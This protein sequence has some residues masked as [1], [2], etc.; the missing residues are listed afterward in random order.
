MANKNSF[1]DS[2]LAIA[3]IVVVLMLI[4]PLPT[5]LLDALMAMNV[6][7]S[8]LVLL[9]VIYTPRVIDFSSFPSVLLYLTIFSLG[10]NVSST[11]L[12]LTQG[13][14]FNGQMVKAFARFVVGKEGIEGI[15]V[16]FVIFIIL[17]V[18]QSI[19]ISKGASRVAEVAARFTLDGM[20]LKMNAVDA[21]FHS[22]V[23]SEEEARKRKLEIQKESDFF[24]NMD[25]STKFVSGNVKAGIFITV[26]NLVVGLI[27]GMVLRGESFGVAIQTYASLTIGDGLLSQI[28]SLL[29]SFATGLIVTRSASDGS[30]LGS[31]VKKE[32]SQ[33]AKVYYVGGATIAL[34]GLIPSFPWYV[35][36]PMGTALFY[37]GWRLDTIKTK[38]TQEKNLASEKEKMKPVSSPA[39]INPVVPLDDL[40][41]ELGYGILPL[42]DVEK[43]GDLKER[44]TRI[45]RELGLDLGLVVPPIHMVDNVA[46]EP[47]EYCF[48]IRGV[49]LGRGQVRLGWYMC[50]NTGGVIE[51]IPGEATTDP[52]FGL[53]AILV[54]EENRDRAERMGYSVVDPPTIIATH[55]TEMLK[56]NAADILGRQE[57]QNIIDELGKKYSAVVDEVTKIFTLGEI[58]KVLQGL[59][60]EQV[61]IRNNVAILETMADYGTITKK[62][63]ILVEKVRQALGRQICLQYVDA[64]K[65]LHVVTVNPRFIQ[66]LLDCKVETLHGPIVALDIEE[67]RAWISA[68]AATFAAV[69]NKGYMPIILCQEEARML[70]KQSTIREMP[71]LVV[72]SMLELTNDIK[73]ESLGEINVG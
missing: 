26:V 14:K 41:L 71:G 29:V 43:G 37:I 61:S 46:L 6:L 7:L 47:N 21:E 56:A 31:D 44:I 51:E 17:I 38:E 18:V 32:F 15:L 5:I 64:N 3:A 58:Q 45:R 2:A 60:K 73:V 11:R 35:L 22:G 28:P 1:Q 62:T 16:G 4:I 9:I 13:T 55:L 23:I 36:T 24:G 65:V 53:P 70:I 63:D 66:R 72:L 39:G 59:L 34:M 48:K 49:E 12:I 54:T 57:V 20:P 69:Q 8:I 25:G 50:M 42:I 40:S 30:T 67:H 52:A 10:L 19:V 27:F 33:D 68:L